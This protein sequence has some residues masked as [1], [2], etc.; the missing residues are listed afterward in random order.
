MAAT[1]RTQAWVVLT[2]VAVGAAV[3]VSDL[4]VPLGVAGGVP[5][6]AAVLIA[7]WSPRREFVIA[8]ASTA[9]VLT[10]VGWYLSPAG[11]VAWVVAT[12]RVLAALAIVAVTV[13]GLMR[14]RSSKMLA[15]LAAKLEDHV[16]DRT[17]QL[18]A[19]AYT[20][21][22]DLRAPLRAM[23]GFS[24][25]LK[26]DYQGHLDATGRD[27]I[28]R[29]GDAS[30][31]MGALI[32]DLL[33]YSRTSRT[34]LSFRSVHLNEVVTEVLAD[35]S[36]GIEESGAEIIV[37]DSLPVMAVHREMFVQMV[38]N[39]IQNALKFIPLG[40]T[41]RVRIWGEWKG[42]TVR[43]WVE[44]NG[45]GIDARHQ[46]RIFH[47]FERLHGVD[48][49]SGTGVGLA[50]VAKGAQR[51]GGRCGVESTLG[52]GSRFWVELPG[53]EGESAVHSGVP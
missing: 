39:L 17:A 13:L 5:Y 15:D 9:V 1:G 32:D 18:E 22:H 2:T 37:D 50:L 38:T 36:V 31:R 26:E 19:F 8:V 4:L 35:L 33:L 30:E 20:V 42:D 52:E 43:L 25:A 3:L 48:E 28:R 6:I 34:E 21:S 40:G 45:I 14:H 11:G 27:H 49:Y 24:N 12:N 46:D 51:M 10:A 53:G 23:Q 41:P 47:V 29:I 7:L 44:D 16:I